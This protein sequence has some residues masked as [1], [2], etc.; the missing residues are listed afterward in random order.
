MLAMYAR[1]YFVLR[2]A[3]RSFNSFGNLS[4]DPTS[5]SRTNPSN[6]R[7]GT[8]TN[9]NA[10]GAAARRRLEKNTMKLKKVC[11]R[12]PLATR[13]LADSPQLARLMLMYPIAYMIVWTLPTAIRIYQTAKGVPAPF[14]LQTV[15]KVCVDKRCSLKLY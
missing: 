9:E 7:S 15:D 14:A 10:N 1:L 4:S 2:R 11:T 12:V 8:L 13:H 5:G 3:H 6:Q